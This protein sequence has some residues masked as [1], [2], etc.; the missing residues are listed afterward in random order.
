MTHQFTVSDLGLRLIKAYEGYRSESRTLV[1]GQNVVGYGHR[2]ADQDAI[3]L[4][5][6]EAETLL[7]EDI[8][9]VEDLIN[10]VTFAPLTQG[11]FDALCSLAYNIGPDAFLKS[12]VL[13]ALNNG[14]PIEAAN[15]FDVWRKG[16]VGGRSYIIDALVRRRTAE[17]ALFLKP[18]RRP[19]TSPRHSLPPQRAS[20]AP[21]TISK[22]DEVFNEDDAS[23]Y[24]EAVPY[25]LQSVTG[26]RREDGPAGILELSEY[27]D[28]QA[29]DTN[30]DLGFVPESEVNIDEID[31]DSEIE[32]ES[33]DLVETDLND[34]P[35]E[36][37]NENASEDSS[38]SSRAALE[39]EAPMTLSP[40]AEAAAEVSNRLDALI[41]DY[42]GETTDVSDMP[43]SLIDLAKPNVP[44]VVLPFRGK[45]KIEPPL[46]EDEPDEALGTLLESEAEI[47]PDQPPRVAA[48]TVQA[49]TLSINETN[50]KTESIAA[51]VVMFISGLVMFALSLYA[52]MK[53]P[54]DLLG[55]WG[56]I[57]TLVGLM[58]GGMIILGSVYYIMKSSFSGR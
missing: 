6:E 28:E 9:P 19:V 5:R 50:S 34:E 12:D 45:D 16:Q 46:N 55:A 18:D 20:R 2:I 56:P 25:D 38:E 41:D 29:E 27:V 35:L 51:F 10:E 44:N 24:V 31:V 26:R 14:R 52:W 15:G 30:V 11:Q 49:E 1:S 53:N 23:A 57:A 21:S 7:R 40:I 43:D 8:L 36:S 4:T 58:M 13:R 47:I 48:N 39:A 37:S 33:P 42:D 22:S 54:A 3:A 32:S 17:K